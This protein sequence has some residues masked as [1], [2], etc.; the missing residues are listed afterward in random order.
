MG[1][2]HDRARPC[3]PYTH[4]YRPR[5]G[6]RAMNGPLKGTLAFVAFMLV[7]AVVLA[8]CGGGEGAGGSSAGRG[9]SSTDKAA[10]SGK[11]TTGGTTGGK[12]MYRS[13]S[14]GATTTTKSPSSKGASGGPLK[15]IVIEETEFNLSPSTVTLSKPGTYAF[16]AENEG[17]AEHNL[18]IDG[19]GVESE[20]GKA[21]E[22]R[23]E[24]NID[25]GESGVLTVTFQEP[26][27]YEMYCPVI[28]HRL[29]GM[30]GEVVVK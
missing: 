18:E 25:S 22:A 13:A 4:L 11:A 5:Q 29:A 15:T 14:S 3:A 24:Q 6:L 21:G 20:G 28:G 7:L 8:S 19:K 16:K 2:R 12:E 17:S 9:S 30:K 10:T 23:L 27:T 26:G 1:D